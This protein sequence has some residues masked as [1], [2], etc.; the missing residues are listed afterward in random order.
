MKTATTLLEIFPPEHSELILRYKNTLPKVF[1]NYDVAIFMA[2]KAI[3]FYKALVLGGFVKEPVSCEILTD[4][5]LSYNIFK[6][7]ENKK[8]VIIDDVMIRG[9]SIVKTLKILSEEGIKADVYI[10]AQSIG[11]KPISEEARIIETFSKLSDSDTKQLSKYIADFIAATICPYNIDQPIYNFRQF[12]SERID[13]FVRQFNLVDISSRLQKK[14]G[15]KNYILEIPNSSFSDEVIG[16]FVKLCKIRF[17]HGKYKKNP[18]FLAT[19]FILFDEMNYS[20]LD[21]AFLKFN[22]T[23]LQNFIYNKQEKIIYENKIKILSYAISAQLMD[24]FL[25]TFK[26]EGV[27]RLVN[28]DNFVFY[29]DILSM[30]NHPQSTFFFDIPLH[31]P[32]INYNYTFIRNEYLQLTY[33]FLYSNNMKRPEYCDYEGKPTIEKPLKLLILSALEE[34]I[35]THTNAELNSLIFSSIIDVLIDLG[36]LIPTIVHHRYN[37]TIIRAYKGGEVF[38]LNEEHFK[39]FTYTLYK[40]LESLSQDILG[41]VEFEKL[42]VMFFR[43]AIDKKI[44]GASEKSDMD[45]EYSICYSKFGPRV[46]TS[47]RKYEAP[48]STSLAYKL[49]KITHID[50]DKIE[51]GKIKSNAENADSI[52]PNDE[53]PQQ[54]EYNLETKYTIKLNEIDGI[55]RH[56]SIVAENFAN[57]FSKIYRH[58]FDNTG[59]QIIFEEVRDMHIYSYT[60]LLTLMA[61]GLDKKE[62]LLSLLAEVHLFNEKKIVGNIEYILIKHHEI[63]D[64]IVSGMW[65]YMCYA[66]QYKE[67]TKRSEPMHPIEKLIEK[68]RSK[69]DDISDYVKNDIQEFIYLNRD[70]DLN[71]HIEPLMHTAGK[72]IYSV[73]YAIWFMSNKYGVYQSISSKRLNLEV[74]RKREFFFEGISKEKEIR[75]LRKTIEDQVNSNTREQN[76]SFLNGLKADSKRILEDYHNKIAEGSKQEI[77]SIPL[78]KQNNID[79][80]FLFVTAN[81]HEKS[82]FE[83][84]FMIKG[85]HVVNGKSCPIGLFGNYDAIHFHLHK[86]GPTSPDMSLLAICINEIKPIAVVMPGIA[87]GANE[88]SQ[89]E[90]DKQKIG[91]IL[92]SE[93]IL[94][95]DPEKVRDDKPNFKEVR[96]DGGFQLL[97]AFR[98]KREWKYDIGGGREPKIIPG[99]ILTGSKLIDEYEF[100]QKLLEAF[101]DEKPI[102]G[103]M[104]AY[105]IFS[106]CKACSIPEWIIVKAICDWGYCKNIDKDKNQKLAARIVMDYCYH[107]FSRPLIF[108]ELLRATPS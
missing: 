7:L 104:E 60:E 55:D 64:G 30:I 96:K 56:W 29:N 75:S 18:V 79:N 16:E 22:N 102:G 62:Q 5:A 14:Y 2:R 34:N 35:T 53:S 12:N 17:L 19:P 27:Q 92:V 52:T 40:Y 91:D 77:R 83:R 23:Q 51:I 24:T 98:D 80:I 47:R 69:N 38:A 15:I 86:Q 36:V 81:E 78:K 10:M 67:T 32:N 54:I 58:L 95:Y 106:I 50:Y 26:I 46:S 108:D 74:D 20:K 87:F 39:L 66:Q 72:L 42:C 9:T 21:E 49:L 85:Y 76:I 33:D 101:K 90:D 31:N 63:F 107:V 11:E 25:E 3:C 57:K 4:R 44:L 43:T 68:L 97:N 13:D 93:N 41:K 61:I 84:F 28:N 71:Q 45:D 82:E 94:P 88:K 1:A 73:A 65:K 8:V 103:E 37:N 105:G 48:E 99:N 6:K 70:I 100:R 59:N 89:N